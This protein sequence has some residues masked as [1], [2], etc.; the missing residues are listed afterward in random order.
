MAVACVYHCVSTAAISHRCMPKEAPSQ[1]LWCVRVWQGCDFCSPRGDPSGAGACMSR[2]Q[3]CTAWLPSYAY[4]SGES[5]RL[6]SHVCNE[7]PDEAEDL[8]QV[9]KVSKYLSN[10]S[11]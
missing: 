5:N 7:R 11:N 8:M 9:I 3:S 2:E 1:I 6:V 4:S 10:G